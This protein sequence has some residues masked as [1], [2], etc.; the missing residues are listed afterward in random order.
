MCITAHQ[1]GSEKRYNSSATDHG[2][3]P[4][5]IATVRAS[6]LVTVDGGNAFATGAHADATG[7]VSNNVNDLGY[8]TVASRLCGL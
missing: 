7:A 1:L 2:A 6:A 4:G 5:V 3:D 8:A